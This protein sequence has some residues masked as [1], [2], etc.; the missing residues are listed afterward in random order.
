MVLWFYVLIKTL[1]LLWFSSLA[2]LRDNILLSEI[3]LLLTL[4][5]IPVFKCMYKFGLGYQN[6][7]CAVLFAGQSTPL[8][9][10]IHLCLWMSVIPRELVISFY[11]VLSMSLR[12]VSVLAV[13]LLIM[14]SDY[15][16]ELAF[17]HI[18]N[19]MNFP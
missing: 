4:F 10:L 5:V 19:S 18:H 2:C 8:Q 7:M 9:D 12:G 16:C 3:T 1:L 15:F 14:K 13:C 11:L 6:T 17:P